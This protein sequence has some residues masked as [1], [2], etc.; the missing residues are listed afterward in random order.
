M[1]SDSRGDGRKRRR[2]FQFSLALLCAAVAATGAILAF[3][4]RYPVLAAGLL[5]VFVGICL[6][7]GGLLVL[8]GEG[9]FED[10][11]AAKLNSEQRP[12][13]S[14]SRPRKSMKSSPDTNLPSGIER[15]T[16]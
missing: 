7:V 10:W 4:L 11:L 13:D 2:R 14:P 15:K 1:R 9:M 5:I 16:D 6:L 12:H 8:L 3:V